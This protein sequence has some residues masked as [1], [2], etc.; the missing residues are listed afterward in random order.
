MRQVYSITRNNIKNY[1]NN[2]KISNNKKKQPP[3]IIPKHPKH[4]LKK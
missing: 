4:K 1:N 2:Q 3:E